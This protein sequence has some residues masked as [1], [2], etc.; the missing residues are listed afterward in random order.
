MIT[1]EEVRKRIDTIT[2]QLSV[3]IYDTDYVT[4]TLIMFDDYIT[5]QEK[6]SKLLELYREHKYLVPFKTGLGENSKR[7]HDIH[8]QIKALEEELK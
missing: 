8:K 4:D 5:Q 7:V 2:Q 1:H 6:V 3:P